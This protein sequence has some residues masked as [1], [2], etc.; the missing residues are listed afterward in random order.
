MSFHI[1]YITHE[2][3]AAARQ[4]TEVLLGEKLIACANLFPITSAYWWQGAVA[5]E[6][7]WVS[8]VKTIPENW[9]ALQARVE[10]L[11]P[12]D[13]PCIMRLEANANAAYEKWIRDS[14]NEQ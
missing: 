11:H 13:V 10:A 2:S 9:M 1:V 12:Y 5:R 7:E 3:E 4:L 6:S 8:I 14:V